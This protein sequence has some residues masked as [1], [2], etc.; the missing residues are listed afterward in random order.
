MKH[1]YTGKWSSHLTDVLWACKSS[2]KTAIGFSPFSLIYGIEVINPVDLAVPTPRVVLKEI[3]GDADY[4]RTKGRLVDLEEL[5]EKREVARRR[6]ERYQQKMAKAYEQAVHPR[7]FVE[8]QL[9]LKAA[10][11]IRKNILGPFKFTPKWE[12]PYVVKVAHDSRY[13]YLARWMGPP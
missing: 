7:I 8:E 12:G 9:V 13:Y 10:K 1:E 3:Q 4:T 11:H 5:E 6:S 2:L